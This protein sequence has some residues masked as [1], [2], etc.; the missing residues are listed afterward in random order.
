MKKSMNRDF[1]LSPTPL[2]SE[3]SFSGSSNPIG[4]QTKKEAKEKK[5][6]I[7]NIAAIGSAIV[8]TIGMIAADARLGRGNQRYKDQNLGNLN[9]P[10]P[11]MKQKWDMGRNNKSTKK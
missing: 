4:P 9:A 2:G 10:N 6:T 7:K 3:V 5:Q 8:G 11:T 1:P